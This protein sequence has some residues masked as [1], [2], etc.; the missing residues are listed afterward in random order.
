MTENEKIEKYGPIPR[1][2]LLLLVATVFSSCS[3]GS[4]NQSADK[5]ADKFV[6]AWVVRTEAGVLGKYNLWADHSVSVTGVDGHGQWSVIDGK[7]KLVGLNGWNRLDGNPKDVVW[8]DL[9][10]DGP[11]H[12]STDTTEK[13]VKWAWTRVCEETRHGMDYY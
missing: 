8:S 3:S 6:G 9:Q 7:L 1:F 12:F 11:N 10:W 4:S 13:H 5:P 2:A